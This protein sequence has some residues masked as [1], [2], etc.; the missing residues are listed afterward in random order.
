M[1]VTTSYTYFFGSQVT[2]YDEPGTTIWPDHNTLAR[3]TDGTVVVGYSSGANADVSAKGYFGQTFDNT[4]SSSTTGSQT[5]PE[6]A[7]LSGGGMVAS[8]TDT[9]SGSSD[10][11]VRYWNNALAAQTQII[12]FGGATT[13]A[14]SQGEVIGLSNGG[15]A[16]T[17]TH[18]RT[19][20]TDVV[21]RFF[22]SAGSAVTDG[23]STFSPEISNTFNSSGASIAA[24]ANGAAVVAYQMSTTTSTDSTI[25]F[26][27]Y[28]NTGAKSGQSVVVD[29]SGT[30]NRNVATTSLTDG[31]FVLAWEDNGF[32]GASGTEIA[33]R[34]YNANGSAR[35]GVIQVNTGLGG[36]QSEA[37]VTELDTGHI[38]VGWRNGNTQLEN[39]GLQTFTTAGVAVGGNHISSDFVTEQDIVGMT[40]G[41][42]AH[43]YM[44]GDAV[45]IRAAS[46]RRTSTGDSA[47]DTITGDSLIDIVTGGGGADVIA[48]LGGNDTISG[49]TGNDT[50]DGGA[51]VD[52]A[53]YTNFRGAFQLRGYVSDGQD[54]VSVQDQNGGGGAE[55]FDVVS[56]IEVFRF[57]TATF[58]LYMQGVQTNDVSNMDGNRNDDVVFRNINTG[59]VLYQDMATGG[60]VGWKSVIGSLP[61]GWQAVGSGDANNDGRADLFVQDNATGSFYSIDISSGSAVWNTVVNNVTADWKVID[62]RDFSRDGGLDVLIRNQSTGVLLSADLSQSGAFEQW[63]TVANLGTGWRTV[64]AGDFDRDGVAEIAVQRISDGL[65]YYVDMDEDGFAGWG[66][67]AGGLGTE[68]IMKAA[69]DL[70][71]DG[72]VDV[73]FQSNV[74]GNVWYTNMAGGA[75]NSWG[76]VANGMSGWDVVGVADVRNDSFADVIMRET[77]TGVTVA[78]DMWTSS[79]FNG[80]HTVA[81]PG[82]DW[83]VV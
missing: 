65:S 83:V 78:A 79:G 4:L 33:M 75:G 53:S 63:T 44:D 40:G 69:G 76:V 9:S 35:T 6:L 17:G 1:A 81:S 29:T 49:G 18:Q 26:Q 37:S 21:T 43:A 31:G 45:R 5:D 3:L 41:Q 60:A 51:G 15:F 61:A 68:W 23:S 39:Y 2:V 74:T 48:T 54:F 16:V 56:G 55:G 32:T 24:L 10:I 14:Y 12:A 82:T 11:Q 30:I 62:I 72:F 13:E 19:G 58:N 8:F 80:W 67:I 36:N 46:L 28:S 25:R 20:H 70:T 34:I 57:G 42:I 47:A 52:L 77:A 71:G 27:L 38:M 73:V 22:D 66:S 59:Q 7:A 64:A 50:I